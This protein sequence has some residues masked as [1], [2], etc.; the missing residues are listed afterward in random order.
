MPTFRLFCVT[1]KP[2]ILP[3]VRD[4]IPIQV[5]TSESNFCPIRD[6]Q[7]KTISSKNATYSELTAMYSIWKNHPSHF[8]GF[9]HY[10]R[11]L[12]PPTLSKWLR[13]NA[14]NPYA[15]GFSL[16]ED[17]LVA[18]LAEVNASYCSDFLPLLEQADVIL[19]Y[20]CT[21]PKGGFLAQYA[22]VH[23][24]GPMYRLL[25][26]LS[27]IDQR[28]GLL[29]HQFFLDQRSAHWC[30]LFI[31]SWPVFDQYS[32]FLFDVLFRL[33]DQIVLPRSQ[34]QRREFAFLSERLFNFWLWMHK[35]KT[36]TVDW[37]IL[38]TSH[39]SREPHQFHASVQKSLL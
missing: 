12:F 5:G 36:C 26:V 11:F 32:H 2:L 14:V 8:V 31:S 27:D 19:P 3:S 23:P 4:L 34:Y 35:I 20:E 15:S 10:R 16:K 21:L 9:C 7:G 38:D 18:K 30:N 1:H 33:E 29:A 25:A 39:L 13:S 17:D 24:I 22:S 28:L 37:A 6:N